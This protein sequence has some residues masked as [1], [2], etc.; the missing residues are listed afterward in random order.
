MV[1]H[2]GFL[3]GVLGFQQADSIA[4][5]IPLFLFSVLFGLLMDYHV[6]LLSRIQERC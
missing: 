2:H 3:A 1:F 4:A 5:W 6:F